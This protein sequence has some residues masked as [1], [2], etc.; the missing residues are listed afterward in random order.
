MR[1]ILI[2]M[3]LVVGVMQAQGVGAN[4]FVL[5]RSGYGAAAPALGGA[6]TAWG[7]DASAMWWNPAALEGIGNGEAMIGYR[8]F[9]A[10]IHDQFLGFAWPWKRMTV[11]AAVFYSLTSVQEWNEQNEPAG[12]I[13]PQSGV[14]HLG[15]AYSLWRDFSVGI[16]SKLLY[17]NLVTRTGFGAV[18]DAG[19][20][21][22]AAD[23]LTL[24]ISGHDLGPGVYYEG[25]RIST[26]WA[27]D[28]GASIEILPGIVV[29]MDAGYVSDAG[30]DTRAGIEYRPIPEIAL[31]AGGRFNSSV[32]EWGPLAAPSLGLAIYW[33]G[34]RVE[35]AWVPC[36][37]LG[38]T[39]AVTVARVLKA[40]PAS[41]D[42]LVKV[43]DSRDMQPLSAE[44]DM[45]GAIEGSYQINGKFRRNWVDPGELS[46][47]AEA[48]HHY[49]GE[50]S[51]MLEPERLNVMIIPLDSI[52]YGI[53][54]GIVMVE[55]SRTP[56]GATVYFK[57]ELEDSVRSDPNWG[58]YRSNPLPPGNYLVKVDPDDNRLYAT[59]Q[60]VEVPP[61]DTLT[62]DF[63]VSREARANVLMTLHINFET[64]KA[65]ILE[66]FKP[67]LDSITPV[68]GSNADRGL[69]IEIAGHTD[70]V[71]VVHS[72]YGDNQTL[73]EA[74]ARA[75]RDY[76]IG[77]CGLPKEMFTC[78]G[79]GESQPIASNSNP[80]G[81]AMNRRIEFRLIT[82]EE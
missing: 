44:A 1:R 18:F 38:H 49:P 74:R 76:L 71:P 73:S 37:Q 63:F 40:R 8:L 65:E 82:R 60:R 70:N 58:T 36:G 4:A 26:P 43:T 21:W 62:T 46:A 14:L 67:V 20:Y 16:G 59:V 28:V 34:F 78:K 52:P 11:G 27:A 6:G 10:G 81:R 53:L 15:W 61:A 75:I 23:W 77:D 80:E 5:L 72:P 57:G 19:L 22:E 31:R 25:V 42:V 12:R 51:M 41:A 35:Y 24:G 17:D 39:H 64:G 54:E 3:G 55:G 32:M 47:R 68:L 9:V 50:A 45:W 56:T 69:R 13:Y 66:G 30:I 79:Y 2:L 7:R 48:I 33:K 29:S